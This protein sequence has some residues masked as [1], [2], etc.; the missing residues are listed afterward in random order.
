MSRFSERRGYHHGNLREA[1][2]GAAVDLIARHG[3]AGFTVAGINL[4]AGP[5][6]LPPT[7]ADQLWRDVGR[8]L[9]GP[10]VD[11]KFNAF[12]Y[13]PF[14]M[15]RAELPAYLQ[16]QRLAHQRL[17]RAANITPL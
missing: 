13:E 4:L 9:Q 10:D 6:G 8:S 5:A 16:A 3:P 11:A 1:L 14:A 7:V 12:G 2:I 17:V 15:P